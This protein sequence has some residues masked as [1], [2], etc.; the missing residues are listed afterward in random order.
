MSA[1]A[2]EEGSLTLSLLQQLLEEI[3][4]L[5]TM[6]S[7]PSSPLLLLS[8]AE[9]AKRLGVRTEKV[10]ALIRM[11]KLPTVKAGKRERISTDALERLIESGDLSTERRGRPREP[12]PSSSSLAEMPI[13][14]IN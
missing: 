5:K 1:L 10:N 2:V 12:K 4:G 14:P 6:L 8:K 3:R 7:K 11:G 13:W 9:A